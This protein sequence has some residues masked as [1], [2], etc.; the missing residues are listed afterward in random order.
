VNKGI[1]GREKV[2]KKELDASVEQAFSTGL[3]TWSEVVF[4][5]SAVT[6]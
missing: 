6:L 3:L 1:D 5:S 4:D 2:T